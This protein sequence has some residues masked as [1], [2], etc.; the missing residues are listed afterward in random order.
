MN[1]KITVTDTFSKEFK[2]YRKNK[3]FVDA[4]DKKIKRL[5]E[6]PKS[7]G[8]FL[9]GNLHGHKSARIVGKFRLIFKII[10]DR[11]EVQLSAID[12]RKFDYK[13]FNNIK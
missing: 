2:K 10:T 5:Q 3:E 1:W 8:G 9:S 6:N 12:H 7:V 11:Q 13:R 4:L